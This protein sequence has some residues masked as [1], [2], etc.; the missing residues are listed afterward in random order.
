MI[1]SIPRSL[2]N[3]NILE[4][5]IYSVLVVTQKV[6]EAEKWKGAFFI[7]NF[8]VAVFSC[9]F[10]EAT[11]NVWLIQRRRWKGEKAEIAREVGVNAINSTHYVYAGWHNSTPWSVCWTV[12]CSW[13]GEAEHYSHRCKTLIYSLS[14]AYS[15][16]FLFSQS[17]VLSASLPNP[18][19]G[20]ILQVQ[21]TR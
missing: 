9:H 8:G 7:G 19:F 21:K 6:A 3:K 11:N 14:H 12:S 10:R 4:H 20:G 17:V 15:Q 13:R 18:A 5:R 2:Q 16:S 1:C